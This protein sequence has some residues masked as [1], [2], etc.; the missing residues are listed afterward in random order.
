MVKAARIVALIAIAIN[1][2]ETT[3]ISKNIFL[4]DAIAASVQQLAKLNVQICRIE[5]RVG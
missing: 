5:Q 2:E 1:S 3:A 4:R